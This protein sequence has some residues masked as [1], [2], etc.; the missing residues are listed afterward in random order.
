MRESFRLW[1][2]ADEGGSKDERTTYVALETYLSDGTRD[3]LR[4]ATPTATETPSYSANGKAVHK[5]KGVRSL[6]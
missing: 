1:A 3:C 4:E 5:G 6:N 2:D